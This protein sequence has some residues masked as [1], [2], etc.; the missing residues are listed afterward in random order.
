MRQRGIVILG[1]R[2]S[3]SAFLFE[4]LA[5]LYIAHKILP[6]VGHYMPGVVYLGL[7]ASVFVLAFFISMSKSTVSASVRL[8]AVFGVSLL[9][10][11]RYLIKGSVVSG[12]TYMYGEVQIFLYALI[13]I[14][15][16]YKNEFN[17]IRNIT[18]LIFIC[19]G[20][21]A[22]TTFIGNSK[23]ESASRLLATLANSDPTR[24]LY[25]SQNIGGFVLVYEL[26]L[27]VPLII[28]MIK[29][30]KMNRALGWG[31]IIL[32]GM[33]IMSSEYTTALLMYVLSLTLFLIPKITKRK[34]IVLVVILVVL[35][36]FNSLY[37]ADLFEF[38]SENVQS[39]TLATRF[40]ELAEL[41]REGESSADGNATNRMELYKKSI[42]AFFESG[43]MGTWNNSQVGGHSFIFDTVGRYGIIGI[44]AMIIMYRM[45]YKMF[46][47]PYRRED[48][49]PYLFFI[50]MIAIFMAFINP[51]TYLFIFICLIPLFAQKLVLKRIE[52]EGF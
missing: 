2:R 36:I 13:A 50:Y 45:V 22:V 39:N 40:A 25:A 8:L 28:Y 38:L 12:L 7:V 33:T 51:K 52:R 23:Y 17:Q 27:I 44:F 14:V 34:I 4:V 49:Y 26:V 43:M 5:F 18:N 47:G 6:A 20:V 1:K 41:L 48:F 42:N 21:T 9:E 19:Y 32:L 31:L 3:F 29:K 46:I 15:F 30:R 37:F 35:F 11:V 24:Q 10:F 16:I